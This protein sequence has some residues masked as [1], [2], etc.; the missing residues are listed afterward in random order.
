MIPN[1]KKTLLSH[2]KD[3]KKWRLILKTLFQVWINLI[4]LSLEFNS[5]NVG[6]GAQLAIQIFAK[7]L[8][9]TQSIL[10]LA[11]NST[12]FEL[13]AQNISKYMW[14]VDFLPISFL[15]RFFGI[16]VLSTIFRNLPTEGS[17]SS[18]LIIIS[19]SLNVIRIFRGFVLLSS[20]I[21]M[22]IIL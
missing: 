1:R 6:K 16:I 20:G 8:I 19:S 7:T 3:S 22:D 12:F 14:I 4:N 11:Y 5:F 18:G 17:T 2:F 21:P 13:L 9:F 10:Q 15:G